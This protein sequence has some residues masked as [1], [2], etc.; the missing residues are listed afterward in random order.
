MTDD[1]D[2]DVPGTAAA[3]GGPPGEGSTRSGQA[4]AC[5]FTDRGNTDGQGGA[6]DAHKAPPSRPPTPREMQPPAIVAELSQHVIGQA[7]AKRVLAQALRRRVRRQALPTAAEQAAVK[8]RHVL[9]VGPTGSGKTELVRQVAR[10]VDAPMTISAVTTM[11]QV[12]YHGR[13][14]EDV[15]GDLFGPAREL[16]LARRAVAMR[17]AAVVA[18]ASGQV[19]DAL[20]AALVQEL[21]LR[22]DTPR[23]QVIKSFRAGELEE[24]EVKVDVYQE[25][26][27]DDFEVRLDNL[28]KRDPKRKYET[29]RRKGAVEDLR[30][31]LQD[32][33]LLRRATSRSVDDEVLSVVENEGIVVLDEIDKLAVTVG[34]MGGS[35]STLGVQRDLLPLL[36]GTTV[37]TA[38]GRVRT[39]HI[40]FIGAGAFH[41]AAVTDL[42]AEL[43]GRLPLRGVLSRLDAGN[44][45]RVLRDASSN[46]LR[47]VVA[48]LA[49]EGIRLVVPEEA[50]A[51]MAFAAATLND[52]EGDIGARRLYAV[53]EA[54]TEEL[55][56]NAADNAGQ[57]VTLTAG[58]VREAMRRWRADRAALPDRHT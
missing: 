1:G 13:D 31:I 4:P 22:G 33:E 34:G 3:D 2:G 24:Q 10:L 47:D 7:A 44:L 37:R 45:A 46:A 29:V 36:D 58:A 17:S 49:T 20:E 28:L 19:E 51:A 26:E 52:Q 38:H 15:V 23:E 25:A 14:V 54:V 27:R 5:G 40:L 48:L 21:W 16:V 50:V 42:L 11:S 9:L 55:S 35:V 57:T 8:P 6:A 12:G 39:D 43:Q 53:V 30:P 56:Y 18:G 41:T 32:A